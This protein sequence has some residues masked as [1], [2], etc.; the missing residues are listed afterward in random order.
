MFEAPLADILDQETDPKP[1]G[2]AVCQRLSD[3]TITK[4]R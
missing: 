4:K 3:D 1:F 2:N